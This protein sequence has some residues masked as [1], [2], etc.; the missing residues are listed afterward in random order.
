MATKVTI[1][2]ELRDRAQRAVDSLGYSSLDEFVAH[3]LE[4]E[5]KRLALDESDQEVAD[6][7]RGLGYL[8]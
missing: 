8:E 3:C 5:L 2:D 7:L 6:Q 1:S 4:N